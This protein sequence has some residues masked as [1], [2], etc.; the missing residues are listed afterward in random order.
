MKT[1]II[2]LTALL[3]SLSWGAAMAAAPQTAGET[4]ICDV[5]ADYAL[6]VEDYPAAIR[7]HLAVLS[8][9]P[10]NALAHY[11]LGFAYG[12][13]G[14]HSAEIRE[15]QRAAALGLRAFDLYLNLGM[16]E[17]ERGDLPSALAALTTSARLSDAAEP[18][19]ELALVYERQGYLKQA[20]AQIH[21]ALA[22]APT[23]PDYLNTLA[24][25]SAEQGDLSA[26]RRIWTAILRR[27]PQYHPAA[28]NLDLLAHE[29]IRTA[30]S[31]P[32]PAAPIL[33]GEA[34]GAAK[35]GALTVTDSTL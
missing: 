3:L 9:D 4:G 19:F 32:A 26:A 33:P 24:V 29:A 28:V 18:H 22:K 8:R 12:M 14:R 10:N 16:A 20:D 17:F 34:K 21:A 35:G 30:T 23:E 5:A 25:L 7:L 1:R 2:P 13:S 11:H 31:L 6:G 15:Y 27:E